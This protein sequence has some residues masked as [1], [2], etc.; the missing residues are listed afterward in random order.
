MP[1][2]PFVSG[3][4]LTWSFAQCVME[5]LTN[6]HFENFTIYT[7]WKK[8]LNFINMKIS[9]MFALRHEN[10]TWKFSKFHSFVSCRPPTP[11]NETWS[12]CRKIFSDFFIYDVKCLKSQMLDM[13]SGDWKLYFNSI[14]SG[15]IANNHDDDDNKPE[16]IRTSSKTSKNRNY[17]WLK[18]Y[19]LID[20]RKEYNPRTLWLILISL[21]LT[22]L[23]QMSNGREIRSKIISNF[24]SI[25]V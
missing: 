25:V 1:K 13:M 16:T 9:L 7:R 10:S 15:F 19:D 18:T 2:F 4:W 3:R 21:L 17:N 6:L 23:V 24:L 12:H 8:N 14:L 11:H 20:L 5:N 22:R